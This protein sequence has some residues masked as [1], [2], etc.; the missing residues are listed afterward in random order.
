MMQVNRVVP[1]SVFN[2]QC[3]AIREFL[4]Q[5]NASKHVWQHQIDAVKMVVKQL[6]DREKPNIAL[7][8]LPTGCGKTGVAVLAAYALNASR[9]LVITPSVK[10]SKQIHEA[11]C[12]SQTQTDKRCF[13]EKRGIFSPDDV[14]YVVP[15]GECITDSAKIIYHY[16]DPFMVVNAH[17]IGG[18]SSVKI[19]DIRKDGYDLVIVDEAHHYPAP[20][21]KTLVDHFDQSR[22]LFITATPVYK[23]KPILPYP[24][25]FTLPRQEAIERGIIRNIDFYEVLNPQGV[26]QPPSFQAKVR[27]MR[28]SSPQ[29][30]CSGLPPP[31]PPPARL[32]SIWPY[33]MHAPYRPTA[34]GTRL[35]RAALRIITPRASARGKAIV[36]RYRCRCC[37]R[38]ENRQISSSRCLCVL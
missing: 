26:L 27:P 7:V 17:K 5:P 8:V 32:G 13:L 33:R 15:R 29:L 11:F 36:C 19:E 10:I 24:P 22:R 4:N 18:L 28:F 3:P 9:V 34:T 31:P 30:Y 14:V 37:C 20:T 12:G 1:Q 23:G 35:P 38:H 25:C 16:V 2:N 6:E 21:W